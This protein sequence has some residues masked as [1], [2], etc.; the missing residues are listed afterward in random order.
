MSLSIELI[1]SGK[2]CRFFHININNIDFRNR[3]IMTVF[4]LLNTDVS[5]VLFCVLVWNVQL[6]VKFISREICKLPNYLSDET[7]AS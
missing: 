2:Y 4:F 5:G 1:I 6:N 3:H 7:L